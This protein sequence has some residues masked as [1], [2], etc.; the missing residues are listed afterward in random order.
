MKTDQF[1]ATLAADTRHERP[2]WPGVLIPLVPAL[3]A[4]ALFLALGLGVREDFWQAI[5]VP[6]STMRLVL[7][8][9]LGVLALRLGLALAQPGR[10]VH[11]RVS[12]VVLVPLLA[13]GLWLWAAFAGPTGGMSMAIQGK[14][15]VDC[16]LFI[17]LLAI[18]PTVALLLALRRGAT[19]HPGRTAA[20]AGLA[21]G[22]F[23]AAIYALHCTEDSPLFY[24]TWY[25]T[26]ILVVTLVSGML[27]RR[28]L[29]W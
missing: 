15:M 28:L 5:M 24:V 9:T 20:A 27:G 29:R 4:S 7:S 14:T 8:L 18:L 17:P 6:V 10:E 16:L 22:G 13:V 12:V 21:G 2:L 19:L 25:G 1:I 26:A 3:A 11:A 23:A